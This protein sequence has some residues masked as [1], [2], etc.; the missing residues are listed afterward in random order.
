MVISGTPAKFCRFSKLY[1]EPIF[2]SSWPSPAGTLRMITMIFCSLSV[3]I[4]LP[5]CGRSQYLVRPKLVGSRAL[6]AKNSRYI[7][8]KPSLNWNS[9]ILSVPICDTPVHL[10]VFRIFRIRETRG[11]GTDSV[12]RANSV[13]W[14]R[15]PASTTRCFFS[16]CLANLNRRILE[17]R[18]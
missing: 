6:T 2:C 4:M 14:H 17:E 18:S 3:T 9:R 11:D 5:L 8:Y 13:R 1:F 12:A 10:L 7:L 15:K 16:S